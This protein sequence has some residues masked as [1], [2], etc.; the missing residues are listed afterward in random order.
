MRCAGDGGACHRHQVAI[1]IVGKGDAAASKVFD[2]VE[3]VVVSVHVVNRPA[4]GICHLGQQIRRIVG[5][6]EGVAVAVGQFGNSA[7][8]GSIV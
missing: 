4:E 3:F 1:A 6:G 7:G 5:K 2:V 8:R